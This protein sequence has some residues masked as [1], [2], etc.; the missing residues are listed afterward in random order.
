MQ[1][2]SIIVLRAKAAVRNYSKKIW[3]WQ[4]LLKAHNSKD[5]S[6][7]LMITINIVTESTLCFFAWIFLL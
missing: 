1:C 2:L 4:I 3:S 7:W 5:Y 6:T